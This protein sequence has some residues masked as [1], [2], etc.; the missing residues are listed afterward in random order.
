M[1]SDSE[2]AK[3]EVYCICPLV[4]LSATY[5]EKKIISRRT[6]RSQRGQHHSYSTDL[7]QLETE[8]AEQILEQLLINQTDWLIVKTLQQKLHYSVHDKYFNYFR[9]ISRSLVHHSP[10]TKCKRG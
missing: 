5:S 9:Q 8:Q 4:E 10:I 6:G 3:N 2:K 7:K 1:R